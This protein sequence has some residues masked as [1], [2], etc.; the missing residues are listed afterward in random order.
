MMRVS[1]VPLDYLLAVLGL[2]IFEM[3]K[4]VEAS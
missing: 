1:D 2:E 4:L 3:R